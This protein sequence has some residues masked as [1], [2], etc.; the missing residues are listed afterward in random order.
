MCKGSHYG[1][2]YGTDKSETTKVSSDGEG[3][4]E[5]YFLNSM[6]QYSAMK[7]ICGD[8]VTKQIVSENRF[9]RGKRES[10]KLFLRKTRRAYDQGIDRTIE[11]TKFFFFFL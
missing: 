1:N 11:S 4:R 5:L 9:F 2:V 3:L 6:E 10:I 8:Y 7:Y